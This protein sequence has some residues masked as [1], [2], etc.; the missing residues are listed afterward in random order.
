MSQEHREKLKS[1]LTDILGPG[2]ED[3]GSFWTA[4]YCDRDKPN[5]KEGIIWARTTDFNPYS[6]NEVV[7]Y[8]KDWDYQL[9]AKEMSE[10]ID[11]AVKP[12]DVRIAVRAHVAVARALGQGDPK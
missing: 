1:Q 6:H 4:F 8:Y 9:S 3:S 5:R 12:E 2:K 10:L 11:G 7:I